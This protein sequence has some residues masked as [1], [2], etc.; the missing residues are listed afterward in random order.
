MENTISSNE[1]WVGGGGICV[2][3]S[4]PTI[5]ANTISGNEAKDVGG[6]G[7]FVD[8]SSFSIEKNTISGNVAVNGGGIFVNNATL[9]F[10]DPDD[11]IYEDNQP[12]DIY[13]QP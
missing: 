2:M 8:G 13:Y 1:A 5:E 4:S 9:I 3:E 12:D 10:N 6:G 7:I 11:N